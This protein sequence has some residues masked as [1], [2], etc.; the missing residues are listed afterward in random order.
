MQAR[1]L[2]VMLVAAVAAA[3]GFADTAGAAPVPIATFTPVGKAGVAAFNGKSSL[4]TMRHTAD[5]KLSHAMT[6]DA[7]VLPSSM[8]RGRRDIIVK[9]RRR[10]RF[11][12]GLELTNG[13]LDAY[14][15]IGGKFVTVRA[16]SKLRLHTWS[17][18]AVSY[19][20]RRV[21]LYVDGHQV[22]SRRASGRLS[23]SG[24]PLQI[25][26]DSVWGRH[27]RGLI[28]Y[29]RI[30]N[31]SLNI[32][33]PRPRRHRRSPTKTKPPAKAPTTTAPTT[34]TTPFPT[35]SSVANLWVSTTGGNC[36]RRAAPGSQIP[37]EDC[38]SLNAA[39]Q[40]AQC[41]DIV[42]ID[43]GN[44]SAI[45]QNLVDRSAL[46]SFS[47]PVVFEAGPGVTRSTAVF[48]TINAGNYEEET[49]NGASHWTLQGVTVTRVVT[50]MAPAQHVVINDVQGGTVYINGAQ[51]V[52]V[53]N[54]NWG[55]C[56]SGTPATGDCTSNF[57]IDPEWTV[58]GVAYYTTNIDIFRNEFYH[59]YNNGQTHFECMFLNGGVNETVDSNKFMGCQNYGIFLQPY[60]GVG[61]T[62]LVIENNWFAETAGGEFN[63]RIYA[64][65]FGTNGTAISNVLIRYN[66][67]AADEGITDDGENPPGTNDAVIGNII[68]NSGTDCINGV[69]YAYNIWN[70]SHTCGPGDRD[71]SS[72]PYVDQA[73]GAENFHLIPGSIA[74]DFVVPN[75]PDYELNYDLD[76]NARPAAGPRAG[77]AE[78][79]TG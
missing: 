36:T 49:T 5:L 66:S 45:T 28:A 64:V 50:L 67:F 46:D 29:A 27:F 22:G 61:F 7:R 10:A 20:G 68:G 24:G 63:S 8:L 53:E 76:G 40:A 26:G 16:S 14:V 79:P 1:K 54:S 62:N 35:F 17:L 57:K 12:Y 39:Y 47:S 52:T 9:T 3:S 71:I 25:G 44:Y 30:Y 15:T 69:T 42:N 72:L 21:R 2:I 59:F 56:Y 33:A 32:A 65:D 4:V 48:G 13:V 31:R 37:S 60:S 75:A 18:V 51:N 55:P 34:T 73:V 74:A 38:G 43:A 77:G 70:Y 11:P 41:G 58:S 19:D 23:T 78:Q 6:L